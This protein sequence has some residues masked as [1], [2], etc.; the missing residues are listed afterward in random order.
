ML[1]ASLVARIVALVIPFM[2][3]MAFHPLWLKAATA[4][5]SLTSTENQILINEADADTPGTDNAEFVELY[6]GGGGNTSLDGLVLVFFNGQDDT[7]YRVFDLTGFNTNNDGY[8]IVGNNG[9]PGV[10]L[11]FADNVLQNG[12][13]AV[14]LY[15]DDASSFPSGTIVTTSNLLD[16]LVYDTDQPDDPGLLVLIN[17]GEPQVNEN[18]RQ[19]AQHHSNQRCPNGSGGQRNTQSYWQELPTPKA[20]NRCPT[21]SDDAPQV[22]TI[23][24]E[25]NGQDVPTDIDIIV[26]F[27]EEVNVGAGWYDIT[28]SN[29]GNHTAVESGGGTIFTLNP[30]TA[31]THSE[32]C[33]ITINGALVADID[34]VDPPDQMAQDFVSTFTTI[35]RPVATQMLINE[36]DADT[37]GTDTAEFIEL[38]DGGAGST[39]LDGLVVVFFNGGDDLSY[40]A[41]DLDGQSTDGQ[42]YF[43]VGGT[44]VNGVDLVIPDG[45]IQNGADAVAIYSSNGSDFPNGTAVTT[46]NLLDVLVYD[47]ADADDNELLA[48]LENGEPQMDEA[49]RGVP[50]ADSNQRCPNGSGGQRRTSTYLQNNPTPKASN[51]CTFDEPPRVQ[52]T[53]PADGAEN[54]ARDASLFV[55]ISESVHITPATFELTCSASGQHSLTASGGPTQYTLRAADN[56]RG[57]ESC[58][59]TVV[60]AEVSDED[61]ADP[62][63]H[64]VS[65]YHWTFRVKA[66]PV[67]THI[68]INEVDADT[69]GSDTAEFIE[70][71][72]GGAGRTKL[73][74]LVLVLYNGNSD[75]S[76][77]TLDLDGYETS[78][79]GYF[80]AGNGAVPKV[81]LLF[82]DSVMQ[83]GADAVAVY[84]ANSSDFPNGTAVTRSGLLDALVY[85]TD[86][87]DDAGLLVLLQNGQPQVN[88]AARGNK[89]LDANQRCPN[90]DG[91]QQITLGY[92]QNPPTPGAKNVC[93]LD[94]APQVE[95]T[96]PLPGAS[97]VALDSNITI[98]FSEPVQFSDQWFTIMCSQSLGHTADLSGGPRHFML[99]PL[100]NFATG[101]SCTVTLFGEQITD[102]DGL[103]DTLSADYSW[104][105]TTG[106]PAFGGCGDPAT[107]ISTIQG[108]GLASPLDGAQAILVEGIVS[109]D[110][111]GE[112]GL[113]GFFLQE[114]ALDQDA[115]PRSSEAIF[116]HD[117][118]YGSDVTPGQKVR[119]QGDVSEINGLTSLCNLNGLRSCG[120]GSAIT[121]TTLL[122]PV[123]DPSRWESV[124]G[125]LLS[126]SQTLAVTSN[127]DLGRYGSVDL[128]VDGRLFYPTEVAEAGE[129]ALDV[130]DSNRRSR[131]T[132]DDGSDVQTPQPLPPYLGRQN[133]LRVGDTAD[134]LTGI[135]AENGSGYRIHPTKPVHFT[136]VNEREP[137]P[138]KGQGTLRVVALHTGDFFN[139]DGQGAGFPGTRGAETAEEF[140]RQRSKIIRTILD[141]DA[142]IVGL[143]VLEND[144]YESGSALHDLV[145]GL[146][147]AAASGIT[148]AFVNPGVRQ[149]GL[150]EIAV[151]F[152]YR[153][154]KTSPLGSAVTT[155]NPPFNSA[156]GQ[157]LAQAFT[158][159]GSGEQFI[160][161]LVQLKERGDCPPPGDVN[162]DQNDGQGCWNSLRRK[163]VQTLVTWLETDPTGI[164]EPDILIMGDLNAY[165]REDPIELLQQAGYLNL[166]TGSPEISYSSNIGGESGS[167]IHAFASP[168]LADQAEHAAAWHINADEPQALDYRM[169]NQ[170]ALYMPNAYRSSS[171][172]PIVVDL[173]LAPVQTGAGQIFL[174]LVRIRR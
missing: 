119:V 98:S 73:D 171:Y 162:A 95:A 59:G 143:L 114:E 93:T 82:A 85:D 133:T 105:F 57:G 132:L 144:G 113:N 53:A 140:A 25:H 130:A 126:L 116:V 127:A 43:V 125:M 100:V 68:L 10:D 165:G 129:A 153:Q 123:P 36:V 80:V 66:L 27:S 72:D 74:G 17:G 102:L 69:P 38:F 65:N 172:D 9:A 91:G 117:K 39:Y 79:S 49:G 131:I 148:Y 30:V 52:E 20:S 3:A 135:L 35:A 14:A 31:F 149:L 90:G 40:R 88:E 168:N 50:T 161:T 136:R 46:T 141:I 56:F 139:G 45:V 111:Q 4:T 104:T 96:N 145:T 18:D 106:I 92:M 42:G 1:R 26:S 160:A 142:D 83:N 32:S 41:I 151:G 60:A 55:K 118:D 170:A 48:L 7:S 34:T 16:A 158:A 87:A 156:S 51:N 6:D 110:F 169:T 78:A 146:N 11:A 15:L 86:D 120:S 163:A 164:N 8:F 155:D 33:T 44:A 103:A 147:E 71:Y 128:S 76:Y 108:A 97:D 112:T 94:T 5:A 152:I 154:G 115:D 166:L 157:P 24:P 29:S 47:T 138:V 134:Q 150:G 62:P 124:E 122:L 61:T 54:V 121:P 28:C 75:T 19:I 64:M 12:A 21:I 23:S 77:R 13:D 89:E 70:L 107:P 101:E 22:S 2:G 159:T 137:A 99:D 81:D 167:L 58:A 173:N 67:A 109:G 84:S 37:P 63:D 174:P